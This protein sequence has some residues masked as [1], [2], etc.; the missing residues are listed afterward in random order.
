MMRDIL[1]KRYYKIEFTTASPLTVGGYSSIETDK[2]I[3][4]NGRNVPYIPASA[5]AG[6]Y[7]SCFF[8]ETAEEYFGK[9]GEGIGEN[10]NSKITVY[11]ANIKGDDWFV[12]KRDC[13]AL[14]EFKTTLKGAKFDIQILEPNVR[15]VTYIEQDIYKDDNTLADVI[16]QLWENESI[17]IGSKTT[18]G[19]GR[20]KNVNIKVLDFFFDGEKSEKSVNEWIDFSLFDENDKLWL[21]A[22]SWENV[23]QKYI[24]P[25]EEKTVTI[26]LSMV[27]TSPITIRVYTTDIKKKNEDKSRERIVRSIEDFRHISYKN[28]DNSLTY[29]IPGTSWA[30][31][32]KSNI[33]KFGI[34]NATEYFG[35]KAGADGMG[36][37][38]SEISFS[39]SIIEGSKDKN[40]SR[41]A[42]D[43]FTG[44]TV[45][46]A[47]FTEKVC[48]GGK[49]S[50]EITLNKNVNDDFLKAF[51]ATVTDLHN[52]FM[53]IGGETSIGHGLF[54]LSGI[55]CGNT[56][57]AVGGSCEDIYKNLLEALRSE[58][59]R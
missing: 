18:R 55:K 38:R 25:I 15:F 23:K 5:L 24:G 31:A 21:N 10:Q 11:D 28:H 20:V 53:A 22:D 6:I 3:A 50:L 30:G 59:K 32:F 46:N 7:R 57:I 36:G 56:E 17:R 43:R 47:L 58:I 16:A 45:E 14:D 1:Q 33:K 42:I 29:I 51:V 2:D 41:N 8:K 12:S 52:G 27:Q 4:Y 34:E 13:V 48:Y 35:S 54:K 26:D 9:I 49:T 39:E 40:I 37:K 44:G 19:M